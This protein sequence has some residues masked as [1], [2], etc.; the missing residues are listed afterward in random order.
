MPSIRPDIIE[1]EL[2]H[3]FNRGVE[4][5]VV[6][7]DDNDYFRFV[8]GLYEFNNSNPVTIWGSSSANLRGFTPQVGKRRQRNEL[9]EICGFCL[10]PTHFH[11]LVRSLCEGGLSLFMKKNG[12]G[13]T[14]Y[15]N[16]RHKRV[17][18]LFQGVYKLKLADDDTYAR[19]LF[20]Y[21]HLNSAEFVQKNWKEGIKNW[22]KTEDFLK[23]YKWSSF[24]NYFGESGFPI[25]STKF[26]SEIFNNREEML[27]LLKSWSDD[28]GNYPT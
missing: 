13:Y 10:M 21:V 18:P 14:G 17:G 16:L 3:V 23:K 27:S 28:N 12:A 9:V 26:F 24:S 19:Q 8:H 22:Q 4:K 2:Y 1:G 20:G 7:Q 5:R 11:L 15:Y 6:F 25:V